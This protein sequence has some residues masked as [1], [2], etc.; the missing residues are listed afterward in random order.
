MF[1]KH[2]MQQL[3]HIALRHR[4]NDAERLTFMSWATI[5]ALCVTPATKASCENEVRFLQKFVR[6]ARVRWNLSAEERR[7]QIAANRFASREITQ[8]PLLFL[9]RIVRV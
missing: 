5:G 3:T 8:A 2:W 9:R 4:L 6:S 1:W 7:S